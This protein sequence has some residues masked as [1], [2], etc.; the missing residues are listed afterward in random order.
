MN[1]RLLV[2]QT[3][4]IW[5]LT[6]NWP[7]KYC[8]PKNKKINSTSLCKIISWNINTRNAIDASDRTPSV[9]VSMIY[10]DEFLIPIARIFPL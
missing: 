8:P 1:N 6:F 5:W 9:N 10:I 3:W 7:S 2:F 4:S